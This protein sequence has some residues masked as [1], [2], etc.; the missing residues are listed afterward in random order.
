MV[1]ST[2][3][4]LLSSR[5][6]ALRIETFVGALIAWGQERL[7]ASKPTV[8]EEAFSFLEAGQVEAS[9]A[10]AANQR[11]AGGHDECAYQSAN[12]EKA[13]IKDRQHI[14]DDRPMAT[15]GSAA[16]RRSTP[17][18][19]SPDER[20]SGKDRHASVRRES[21]LPYVRSW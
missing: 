19:H 8:F 9:R 18:R 10:Q 12:C 13:E 2:S 5:I 4:L 6:D 1:R 17:L 21:S 7:R 14:G 20:D 16:P 11:G 15:K 3:T